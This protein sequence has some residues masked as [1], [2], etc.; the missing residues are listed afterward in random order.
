[1]KQLRNYRGLALGGVHNSRKPLDRAFNMF[2]VLYDPVTFSLIL[3]GGQGLGIDYIT[4]ERF[5]V[6]ANRQT[7]THTDAGERL[8]P[9]TVVGVSN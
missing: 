3:I 1:V 7:D 5:N 4:V 9:A 6:R 8:T 2:L